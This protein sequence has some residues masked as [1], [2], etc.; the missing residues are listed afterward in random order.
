MSRVVTV[1]SIEDEAAIRSA[2]VAYLEDSGFRMLGADDGTLGLALFRRER[3]DVVLCDLRLPGMSGLDVIS[4]IV[5]ES[6]ETPVIVVSGVSQVSDAMQAIKRGAWDF[7]TKPLVDMAVIEVAVRRA[8]ERAKLMRQNRVYR[9]EMEA[10][11]RELARALQQFRADEEAGRKIQLK[12]LPQDNWSFGKYAFTHRLYPSTYLSGDFVD[13][14][15]IDRH[16]TGF[17]MADVSGHGAASAFVTV[18]LKTMIAQYR[19]ALRKE[20]D[21]TILCPEETLHRLDHD[22]RQQRLDKYLT[23]FYG[24]IN[25]RE[26]SLACSS[27]GQYPFPILHDGVQAQSLAFRSPPVGLF[28]DSRFRARHLCLPERFLLLVAS[29]GLLELLPQGSLRDKHEALAARLTGTDMTLDQLTAGLGLGARQGLPDDVAL[30]MVRR[31][32]DHG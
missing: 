7:C 17:Y 27:G 30:L 8:L 6:P 21:E 18:M 9:E 16:H 15:P 19:E 11:N 28:K 23:I 24:V 5:D 10:L 1:L 29:D 13:Y 12:L 3:P 2:L 20:G 26:N 14:F 32:A 31:H 4:A 22:V 25:E